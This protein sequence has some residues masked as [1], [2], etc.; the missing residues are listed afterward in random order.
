MVR[1]GRVVILRSRLSIEISRRNAREIHPFLEA[2]VLGL[3]RAVSF[4]A[5]GWLA[6]DSWFGIYFGIFCAVGF[7]AAYLIVG[8]P[9]NMGLARPRN[10]KAVLKRAAFRAASIGLAAILS[11]AIHRESHALS[12]GV[13]VGLVTG[14][15]SGILVAVAP[16]VEAWV[17]DLPDRRLG[18]YG[19]ILVVIGCLLQTF[20]YVFPLVGLQ[21]M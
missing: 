8:P 5:A 21:V 13:E 16:S 17:D 2:M 11:G 12:Y 1:I 10:D 6:K 4:G 7:V 3:L 18:G 19:A 15:S 14:I 20:Q 9:A